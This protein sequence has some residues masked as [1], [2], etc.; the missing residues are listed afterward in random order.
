MKN[1]QTLRLI[2]TK[3]NQIIQINQT[4]NASTQSQTKTFKIQSS[5]SIN[6]KA[7]KPKQL[8]HNK[9][10]IKPKT[11]NHTQTEINTSNPT[12]KRNQLKTKP[13]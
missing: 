2:K 6:T 4:N 11:L 7:T 13:N 9:I 10:S 1:L 3:R 5:Q 8:N 12:Q